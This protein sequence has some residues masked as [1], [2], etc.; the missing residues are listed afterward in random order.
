MARELGVSQ[1]L[2]S[3]VL[4]GRTEYCSRE[5]FLR[6]WTHALQRGYCPKGMLA[7]GLPAASAATAS[8]ADAA[9]SSGKPAQ[10]I[11]LLEGRAFTCLLLPCDFPAN[12]S[13]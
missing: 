13:P 9:F 4:N 8:A 1:T 5:S 3:Q 10:G 6:I 11:V 2:V 7:G 12:L